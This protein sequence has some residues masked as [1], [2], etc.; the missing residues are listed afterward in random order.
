MKG[1]GSVSYMKPLNPWCPP[2]WQGEHWGGSLRSPRKA[3][4]E[5][6]QIWSSWSQECPWGAKSGDHPGVFSGNSQ[7]LGGSWVKKS[8]ETQQIPRKG[9]VWYLTVPWWFIAMII[10]GDINDRS[11]W[12]YICIYLS[13][14]IQRNIPSGYF[15]GHWLT[16][17]SF[18][19]IL[20]YY[21]WSLIQIRLWYSCRFMPMIYIL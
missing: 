10:L 2:Q 9:L 15:C 21:L 5:I 6:L 16:S 19:A 13:V 17:S 14:D 20:S 8:D 12:T 7:L 11:M 18:E 1:L 4:H 3:P